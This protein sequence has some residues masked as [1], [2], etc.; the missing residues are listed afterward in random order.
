MA[1]APLLSWWTWGGQDQPEVG[2]DVRATTSVGVAQAWEGA[3]STHQQDL[4]EAEGS[5]G[6]E[7]KI[8]STY[9]RGSSPES[10]NV[11]FRAV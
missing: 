9:K 6:S 5:S 8:A 11:E 2:Q 4:W 10:V 7:S 1:S 3:L